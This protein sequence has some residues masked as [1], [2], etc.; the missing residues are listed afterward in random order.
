MSNN[1]GELTLTYM[2]LEILFI[3]T[4]TFLLFTFK[5]TR[6]LSEFICTIL[7]KTLLIRIV[8]S[9]YLFCYSVVLIQKSA[10]FMIELIVMHLWPR[11]VSS[12]SNLDNLRTKMKLKIWLCNSPH[13]IKRNVLLCFI[14]N[15]HT[16]KILLY[17]MKTFVCM[18]IDSS[19]I[20]RYLV[21]IH[22][23]YS[24]TH[25]CV[26]TQFSFICDFHSNSDK[27]SCENLVARNI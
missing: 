23:L 6:I 7:R 5:R 17:W 10:L 21:C 24:F 11:N 1:S 25:S 9:S 18:K 8:L 2:T 19:A 22:L 15:V 12:T 13:L 4:L 3:L 27:Y 16:K 14:S 26:C 20:Y